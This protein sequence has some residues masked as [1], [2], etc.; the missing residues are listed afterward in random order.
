[1]VGPVKR[2]DGELAEALLWALKAFLPALCYSRPSLRNAKALQLCV[3]QA[4]ACLYLFAAPGQNRS[5][6]DRHGHHSAHQY[7]PGVRVDQH[8]TRIARGPTAAEVF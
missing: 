3:D 2:R 6:K 4:Q 8:L 7:R 1:M 5:P